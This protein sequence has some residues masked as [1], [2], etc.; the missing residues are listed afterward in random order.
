MLIF[1]GRFF[2]SLVAEGHMFAV[3][4]AAVNTGENAAGTGITAPVPGRQ[5][6]GSY[7]VA[8]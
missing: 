4:L 6:Q 2:L 1:D 7:C 3:G 5:K 8:T